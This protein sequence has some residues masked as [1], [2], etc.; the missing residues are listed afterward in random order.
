MRDPHAPL[1]EDMAGAVGAGAAQLDLLR[2][3]CA[4]AW[5]DGEFSDDEQRLLADLVARY[6]SPVDG[7]GPS[8]EAVEIIASRSASLELLDQ[9]PR[10]LP[11][12]EDRQLAVKLAYMMVRVS[13][14]PG[15]A[16]AINPREKQAYR[17]LVEATGLDPSEVETTE[18]AAEA[19]L[20]NL[21]GGLLGL[22][23]RAFTGLGPWPEAS[24]L[25]QP[26]APRL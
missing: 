10:Q 18:W 19:E 1:P 9:L 13:R 23:R 15:D 17:R 20:R 12:A 22:L 4:V 5:C 14:R 24:L 2:I 3:V 6:L 8:A 26:G 25:Q 7:N 11:S 21:S 16:A